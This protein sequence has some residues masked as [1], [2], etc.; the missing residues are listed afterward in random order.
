LGEDLGDV[1]GGPFDGC[2]LLW[3]HVGYLKIIV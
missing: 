3:G 1:H 2:R